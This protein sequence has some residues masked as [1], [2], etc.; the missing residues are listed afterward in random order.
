MIDGKIAEIEIMDTSGMEDFYEIRRT[1][2][3]GRDGYILVFSVDKK[4]SF[5]EL[6]SFYRELCYINP[7]RDRPLVIA[8]NKIDLP[9][10]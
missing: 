8:A 1:W 3:I 10:K 6:E 5:L 9:N 4:E 7:E 2:M